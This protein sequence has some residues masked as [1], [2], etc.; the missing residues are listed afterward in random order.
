MC[1]RESFNYSITDMH[2][3]LFFIFLGDLRLVNLVAFP[4]FEDNMLLGEFI[5]SVGI[6]DKDV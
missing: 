6:C 4:W 1:A 3:F 2:I 5:Y